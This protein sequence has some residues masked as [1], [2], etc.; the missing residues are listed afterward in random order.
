[1]AK[2]DQHEHTHV[3][4]YTHTHMHSCTHTGLQQE[5]QCYYIVT[6]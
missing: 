5:I 1:M 6:T 2:S 3:C 4:V